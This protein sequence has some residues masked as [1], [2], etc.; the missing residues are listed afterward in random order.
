LR[1]KKRAEGRQKAFRSELF[2]IYFFAGGGGN[3]LNIFSTALF[4]FLVFFFRIVAQRIARV[5]QTPNV[6][7]VGAEGMTF[8]D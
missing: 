1:K 7:R 4:I 6:D 5:P 2:M 3:F 8:T